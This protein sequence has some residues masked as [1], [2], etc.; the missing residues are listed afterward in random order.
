MSPFWEAPRP[1]VADVR[2]GL[3]ASI[4]FLSSPEYVIQNHHDD[5][6]DHDGRTA[7]IFSLRLRMIDTTLT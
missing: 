1:D 2:D 7:S 3:A 6:D 4:F 5:R